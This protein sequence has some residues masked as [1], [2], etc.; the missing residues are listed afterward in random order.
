MP[1]QPLWGWEAEPDQTDPVTSF[2]LYLDFSRPRRE[3]NIK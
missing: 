2:N 3:T 1:L